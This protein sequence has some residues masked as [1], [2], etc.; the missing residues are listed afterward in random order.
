MERELV[1][2]VQYGDMR[3]TIAVDGFEGLNPYTMGLKA[4]TKG[5]TAIG[6]SLHFS[7]TRKGDLS[8][9][10][11]NLIVVDGELCDLTPSE[12]S[13]R[14]KPGDK[15]RVRKIEAEVDLEQL[16]EVVKRLDIVLL[17]PARLTPVI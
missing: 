10:G 12:I 11:G 3:G 9:S 17:S 8:L 13:K 14:I 4:N 6:I 2:E 1:A 16:L 5:K 15:V 7:T